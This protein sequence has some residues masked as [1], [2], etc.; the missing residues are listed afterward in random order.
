MTRGITIVG[1]HDGHD[2]E[3]WNNATITPFVFS[4]AATGRFPL[5]GLNT[6]VFKP[7]ECAEAYATANRERAQTMGIVFDWRES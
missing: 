6:H 7:A 5:A 3:R 1:V 4:L 2:D